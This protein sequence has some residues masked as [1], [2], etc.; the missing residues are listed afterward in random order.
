MV[1]KTKV[2]AKVKAAPK[3]NVNV[4][5]K[6]AAKSKVKSKNAAVKAA[7]QKKFI[8]KKVSFIV[9][10]LKCGGRLYIPSGVKRPPVVIMAHGFGAE[11]TFGIPAY[12]E[13]YAKNG[14]AVL[15]F[16]YRYFGES[17]GEPRHYISPKAQ[18]KDWN[19]A[20]EFVR[21]LKEVDGDRICIWG[22]SF[23]GGHVIILAARNS[24][25]KTFISHVPLLDSLDFLKKDGF[26]KTMKINAAIARDIFNSVTGRPP[27]NIAVYGR[28][29][30]FAVLNAPESYEGYSSMV[31]ENSDWKNEFPARSALTFV[32]YRP[33]KY[34]H[35]LRCRGMVVYV[36][37]DSVTGPELVE[38]A[39]V[40]MQDIELLKLQCGHFKLFEGEYFKKTT[41]EEF[42]FLKS[43]FK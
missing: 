20:I 34:I 32:W 41:A 17:E 7:E 42:R 19:S 29:E 5:S 39:F 8:I 30:E 6:P 22:C 21:G 18:L 2:K 11:M 23:S 4:K 31:P 33:I 13:K 1:Q 35:E 28:P 10:G 16:D 43:V 40:N 24:N 15:T 37:Y 26:V 12:A 36:E 14:F 25:V 27:H 38:K 9:E 3:A